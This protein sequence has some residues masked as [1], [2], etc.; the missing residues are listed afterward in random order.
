MKLNSHKA[1]NW[2]YILSLI[3]IIT[4]GI[5]RK[6]FLYELAGV[7]FFVKYI[8]FSTTYLLLFIASFNIPRPKY[9]YQFFLSLFILVCFLGLFTNKLNNPLTVSLIGLVIHLAFLPLIHINQFFFNSIDK[10]LKLAKII[11]LI[12]IPIGILGAIQYYLPVDH[13]LNG[14][15]NDEQLI[16]RADGFTRI[17]S[18]FS[19]LK[20][21]NAYLLFCTTFL[22]GVI[23]IKIL[24]NES[25]LLYTISI[26]VLIANM[27]MTASRLPIILMGINIALFV[28]Y[29]FFNFSNLRKTITVFFLSGIVCFSINN[30]L[31]HSGISSISY[32]NNEF[33]QVYSQSFSIFSL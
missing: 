9:S 16:S 31:I 27:F 18:I 23:L 12:S 3:W 32:S 17:S 11:A 1:F 26:I 30:F 15:A 33:S 25:V 7:L 6:W 19:F 22:L 8:L 14:L 4:D 5:P 13:P 2:F 28:T 29:V 21:Y 10:I 20:I 24:R